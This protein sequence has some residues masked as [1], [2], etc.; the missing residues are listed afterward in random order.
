MECRGNR[1]QVVS[2]AQ[3]EV[4]A[5]TPT[6]TPQVCQLAPVYFGFDQDTLEAN[7]R[8]T[9]QANVECMRQRGIRA[10]HVTGYTDPRGTEEYNL[11]LGERRAQSVRNYL[12]SLGV[13]ASAITTSSMGE[14]MATGTDEASWAVDRRAEMSER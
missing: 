9:L 5:A 4:P 3:T 11:A 2:R 6:P 8:A 12:R 10:V 14:E 1:C 13:D 7:A